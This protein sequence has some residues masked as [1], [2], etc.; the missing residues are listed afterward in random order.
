MFARNALSIQ[1]IPSISFII[2]IFIYNLLSD[3]NQV[4]PHIMSS[5]LFSSAFSDYQ[6][7]QF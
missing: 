5:S 3:L 6:I 4:S 2:I 1:L 7:I